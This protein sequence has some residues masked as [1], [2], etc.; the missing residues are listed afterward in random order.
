M[1]GFD[2]DN[3][4]ED[5]DNGF[6]YDDAGDGAA[7]D[8]DATVPPEMLDRWKQEELNLDRRRAEIEILDRCIAIAS[9]TWLWPFYSIDKRLKRIYNAYSTI[10]HLIQSEQ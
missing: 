8:F 2:D 1:A 10:T 9:S 5:E 6:N 4:F 3:G 7:F